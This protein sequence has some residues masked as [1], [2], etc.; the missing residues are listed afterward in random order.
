MGTLLDLLQVQPLTNSLMGHTI[1]IL[2][3][4]S[5]S[6]N[7]RREISRCSG[8]DVIKSLACTSPCMDR[9]VMLLAHLDEMEGSGD[10]PQG[11]EIEER[12]EKVLNK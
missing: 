1:C 10:S 9:L 2:T 3:A 6:P 4:L 12:L 8:R 11:F 7:G 5:T